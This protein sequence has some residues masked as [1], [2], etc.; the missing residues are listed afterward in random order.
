MRLNR[1]PIKFACLLGDIRSVVFVTHKFEIT[2]EYCFVMFTF[3]LSANQYT[4]GRVK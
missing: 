3:C 1:L 2:D 4:V